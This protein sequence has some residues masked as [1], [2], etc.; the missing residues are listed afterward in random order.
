LELPDDAR[1]WYD[2]A[3]EIDA[4]HAV[5]KVS[6]LVLHLYNDDTEFGAELARRLLDEGIEDR[7]GTKSIILQAIWRDTV[8]TGRH[9]ET[10]DYLQDYFPDLFDH[11]AQWQFDERFHWIAIGSM[12]ISAGDDDQGRQLLDESLRRADEATEIYGP[13]LLGVQASIGL[14][15]REG[16]LQRLQTFNND[17]FAPWLW[18]TH[19]RNSPTYELIRDEPE[20]NR[21]VERLD[22]NAAEQR[23][24]LAELLATE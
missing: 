5:S 23:L 13:S 8:R 7:Q 14:G 22:R 20:F 9:R 4:T 10:L 18:P 15:D 24:L 17:S 6:P 16:A 1:P 3:T 19:V 21:L 2:R 11:S 12:M